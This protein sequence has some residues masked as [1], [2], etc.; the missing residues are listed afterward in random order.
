MARQPTKELI[1]AARD[2]VCVRVLNMAG[3]DLSVYRFDYDLTF[4]V[5]LMNADGT[6]YHHYGNRDETHPLSHVSFASLTD[7]LRRTA[8][9]HAA[10]QKAPKPP[11]KTKK[12]TIEK[13]PPMADRIKR[14]KAPKCFH[15][16]MVND[17]R[18]EFAK[19][20]RKFDPDSV[21]RWPSSNRVG[22]RLER[23]G[24]P[25]VREVMDGTPAKKAGLQPGDV[26]LSLDGE[27]VVT[28]GDV[29]RVLES[30]PYKATTLAVTYERAGETR[31]GNF[32]LSVWNGSKIKL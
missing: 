19:E 10:Y 1:E 13:I 6:I 16:H 3:V 27:A 29:Q 14:G 32:T 24:Q 4:A 21:W 7:L 20:K 12:D 2:F 8:P 31:K 5:L 17:M 15:C 28:E 9:E 11:K 26:L 23:D 18:V 22:F 25:K 30:A